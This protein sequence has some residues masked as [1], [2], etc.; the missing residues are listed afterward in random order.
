M[1]CKGIVGF[2]NCRF[3]EFMNCQPVKFMPMIV[4]NY[5]AYELACLWIIT[6]MNCYVCEIVI[7]VFSLWVVCLLVFHNEMYQRLNLLSDIYL[8]DAWVQENDVI[9]L[10]LAPLISFYIKNI[11]CWK[12][13]GYVTDIWYLKVCTVGKVDLGL[14]PKK[15]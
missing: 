12:I 5:R 1:W 4:S 7:K 15:I 11:I 14:F 8:K 9:N 2:T 10:I 6:S 13:T 3:Y